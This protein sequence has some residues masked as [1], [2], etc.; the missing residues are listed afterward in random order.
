MVVVDVWMKVTIVVGNPKLRSRTR[1]IAEMVVEQLFGKAAV[2]LAVIDL[3]EHIDSLFVW[4]S[5]KMAM[6]NARV[7][8]SDLIV[9]ASPTY[10]A[11][12]TG[13]LKA[14]LDRFP[15]SGLR[16]TVA[17]GV[18]TGSGLGHSM[19]PAV[20]LDPLLAE[21]GAIVPFRGLYFDTGQIDQI[22]HLVK[23]ALDDAA[24]GLN[25]LRLVADRVLSARPQLQSSRN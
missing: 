10:K 4:P 23:G 7:A 5:D 21:L 19:A 15:A 13:M 11:T 6:L 12:Y 24:S 2:D 14:F 9:A 22:E 20:N 25:S 8:E 16:G 17:I 3:A 18:M 1:R